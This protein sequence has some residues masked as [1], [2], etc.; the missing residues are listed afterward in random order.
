[1]GFMCSSDRSGIKDT[2]IDYLFY[3]ADIIMASPL[4]LRSL[5]GTEG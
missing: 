3:S 2:E 1:M 4:G 5:I